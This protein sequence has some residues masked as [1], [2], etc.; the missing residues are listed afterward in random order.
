MSEAI[1][2]RPPTRRALQQAKREL[3]VELTLALV[4]SQGEWTGKAAWLL[5]VFTGAA[6]SSRV[7]LLP[8]SAHGLAISMRAVYEDLWLAGVDVDFH[9]R[10]HPRTRAA[11][12][13][14]RKAGFTRPKESYW[15]RALDSEED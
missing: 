9:H 2:V 8:T 7:H 13:R 10:T 14:I 15:S 11:V 12:W 4:E 3:L 1:G 6:D 5:T